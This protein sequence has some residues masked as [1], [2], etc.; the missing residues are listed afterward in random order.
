MALF[1]PNKS[2]KTTFFDIFYTAALKNQN[3]I[4]HGKTKFYTFLRHEFDLV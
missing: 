4:G 2:T 3:K 1:G